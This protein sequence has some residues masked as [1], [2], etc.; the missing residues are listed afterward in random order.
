MDYLKSNPIETGD[1]VLDIGCGWGMLSIFCA[2]HFKARVTGIDA[3]PWVFPYLRVHAAMNDVS[4]KTK[5]CRYE[6]IKP[7]LLAKQ[8]FMAGGDIC[9]WDEL[10]PPLYD[11]I[12]RAVANNVGYIIIADPGRSPFMKLAKRCKKDFGGKLIPW[13][14]GNSKRDVGYLLVIRTNS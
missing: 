9:F 5:T 13:Q 3:D 8:K 4:I 10:V 6:E 1:A 2:K 12:K 7:A 14:V 11:L